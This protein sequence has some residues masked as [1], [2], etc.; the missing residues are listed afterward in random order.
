[1]RIGIIGPVLLVLLVSNA[2]GLFDK[3]KVKSDP[4]A[5]MVISALG[6][7][8]EKL[9]DKV[10][11]KVDHVWQPMWNWL[12]GT[13]NKACGKTA[14]MQE[15]IL[16]LHYALNFV[17]QLFKFFERSPAKFKIWELCPK[18]VTKKVTIKLIR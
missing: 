7:D 15:A 16:Y 3:N 9:Y 11:D 8:C 18:L 5:G 17:D 12:I 10:M 13:C 2:N 1:M 6:P 14:R 4:L